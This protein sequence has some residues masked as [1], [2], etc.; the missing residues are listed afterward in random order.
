MARSWP[1]GLSWLKPAAPRTPLG[2]LKPIGQQ[3]IQHVAE[4]RSALARGA[5]MASTRSCA[6]VH[7]TRRL[8]RRLA[9]LRQR[10][11]A[12]PEL[13]FSARARGKLLIDRASA[14]LTVPGGCVEAVLLRRKHAV[15]KDARKFGPMEE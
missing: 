12:W 5:L 8:P 2:L 10:Q 9:A 15:T 11:A 14:L 13:F 7:A 4:A 1:R 3:Q 6:I